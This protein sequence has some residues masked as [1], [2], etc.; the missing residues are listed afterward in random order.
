MKAAGYVRVSTADQHTA[1]QREAVERFVQ[2]RGWSLVRIYEDHGLSGATARRPALTRLLADAHRHGFKAVIVAKLD[3]LGRS[4]LDLLVVLE[5]FRDLGIEFVSVSEAM[6]T[7]TAAGR[8]L[9]AMI[10]AFG[11]MERERIRERVREG[12]RAA[13]RRQGGRWGRRGSLTARHLERARELRRGGMPLR[14]IAS[15]LHVPR[16]SLRRALG[17]LKASA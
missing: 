3:R 16:T 13:I 4:L 12:V 10:G 1:L 9:Y 14:T 17:P 6:D 15:R 7:S 5:T 2:A 11:E 8:M